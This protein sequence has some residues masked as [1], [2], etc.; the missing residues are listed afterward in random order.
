M[1][2]SSMAAAPAAMAQEDRVMGKSQKWVVLEG[3]FLFHYHVGQPEGHL[4]R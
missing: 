4:D 1:Y 2:Q 3:F